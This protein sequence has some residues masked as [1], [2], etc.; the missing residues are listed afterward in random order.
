MMEGFCMAMPSIFRTAR[1]A[2][3][4]STCGGEFHPQCCACTGAWVPGEDGPVDEERRHHLLGAA[5]VLQ[6]MIR[7]RV[8]RPRGGWDGRIM[9]AAELIRYAGF[10]ELA[11]RC[12]RAR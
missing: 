4:Q 7:D 11:D 6:V 3:S 8:H 1:A 12:E 9:H 2:A 5:D 10:P